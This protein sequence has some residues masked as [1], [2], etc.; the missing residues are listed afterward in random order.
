MVDWYGAWAY[1]VWCAGREGLPWRVPGERGWEKAARGVDG[2][3]YPWGDFLDPSWTCVSSS[4]S[5]PPLPMDV[6]S[7]PVDVS[8]Y[9]IVD[10]AGNMRAWC[11]PSSTT[12]DQVDVPGAESAV[13][14]GEKSS[15]GGYWYGRP[16]TATT[17]TRFT[18][19]PRYRG[20]HIGIRLVRSL[21]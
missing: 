5:G 17:S 9:G 21:P 12:G 16:E 14:T 13:S 6:G 10:M 18:L 15:R 1:A 19:D 4:H 2:R 11:V 7:F 3:L 20:V 8:P